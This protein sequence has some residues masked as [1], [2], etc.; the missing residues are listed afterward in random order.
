M[1]NSSFPYWLNGVLDEIRIYDRL[2]N[3][4]EIK[5]YGDCVA[6]PPPC[7]TKNDFAFTRNPCSPFAITFNT[8][9]TGYDA[10]SWDFGDGNTATANSG[11]TNTYLAAGNYQVRMIQSYGGCN[12]TVIKQF[13]VDLQPDNQLIKTSDTTICAGTSKQ[14]LTAPAL[15]FCWSP[16]TFLSNPN[17]PNPITSTPQDITYYFIS[18]T[19][20][21]SAIINGDFEA[22][23][24]GFTSSYNYA[25][26]NMTEAEYFVGTNPQAWNPSTSTCTDHTSGTGKMMLVNGASTPNLKVWGQTVN[27]TPNTNYTFS[28]WIQAIFSANPA[29]LQFTINGNDIGSLITASLPTCTWTR[30][31]T[32]WNSGNNTTANISIIN[33]NTLVAGNYFALDDIS[34]SPVFL[35]RDSVKITVEKPVITKSA[36]PTICP[37]TSTQLTVGG[38]VSYSWTPASTL[39]NSSISNP[40]ATPPNTTMYYVTVTNANTCTNTDSIKVT[41]RPLPV[42]SVNAPA[43]VCKDG[44]TQ[45]NATG[46][47][48]Y[49]W[50]PAAGL[51]NPGIANPLATPGTTTTYFVQ[52]TETA[53]NNSA[54][55][56]TVVIINPLPDI[57]VSK[58][59]DI[60]CSNSEAQLHA[61]GGVQYSWT[62]AATLNNPSIADPIAQPLVS[63]QYF[64][65]GTDI[66]GCSNKDSVTVNVTAN[67]KSGYFM[68]NAFT[69]NNDG[70][71]DCYGIKYWG[72]IQKLEFS[73]YNRWGQRLFYTKTP[74]DCWDGTYKNEKQNPAVYIYMINATTSC[75]TVFRKGTFALIR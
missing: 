5:F 39:N 34:F 29:K 6:P 18:Q 7:V 14:L 23:N 22:G 8:N 57:H 73:I 28:T 45:L 11:P 59:T 54:N 27:V 1:N 31:Y 60:D 64:V 19:T 3:I 61:I 42:F 26:P 47:D 40:V 50:S 41:V 49:A 48:D 51:S 24:T 10:I 37:N 44:S 15:N 62:P 16:T 52:I 72:V 69:P 12:D 30:F 67:G 46:G 20:G 63:T 4:D 68:A 25:N 36:D 33:K 32:N 65:T 56:S 55:L 38:G 43:P 2:L 35:K 9:S 70:R 17:L 58:S 21:N 75:G 53:C 66:S 13:T 71:N 74:G